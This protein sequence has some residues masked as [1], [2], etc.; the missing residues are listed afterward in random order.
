[1]AILDFPPLHFADNDGLL[2]VGG[3]LEPSSILRAYKSGIFPWPLD[4]SILAWF[5]PPKR[6]LL[7][8][9]ELRMSRTLKKELK[10]GKFL[11]SFNNDFEGV[12][13]ACA[14][15]VNRGEQSGTWITS[16][17]I[18][19]YTAL[20][21]LGYAHSVE[22][23]SLEGKL[24]GGLYGI[25]INGFFSGESMFYRKSGASKYA[26]LFLLRHLTRHAIPFFDCQMV[27]PFPESLGARLVSREDF[28]P[29]LRKQLTQ[30]PIP[31]E[32]SS[33]KAFV[34]KDYALPLSKQ[35]REC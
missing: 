17:M 28:I 16:E 33:P 14:E 12:I 21:E 11:C 7:F 30:S 26:L 25:C 2:G 9:N 20:H 5:S 32:N 35:Q 3:D 22:A 29:L 24:V 10:R 15:V 19:A 23:Y 27:T 6:G 1:M 4:E 18:D 8:L 31:F 13:S 34:W